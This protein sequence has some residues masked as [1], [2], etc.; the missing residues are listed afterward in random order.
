MLWHLSTETTMNCRVAILL[1]AFA[2]GY[3][4]GMS[5][6]QFE[7]TVRQRLAGDRT[8]TCSAVAMLDNHS[9]ARSVACADAN[10]ACE[11]GS[12]SKTLTARLL[13]Q[14]IVAGKASLDDPLANTCRR[15]P[16]VQRLAGHAG[17]Y[18]LMPG[19]VLAVGAELRFERDASGKVIALTLLQAGQRLRGK[20]G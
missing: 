5:D 7:Q 19:F 3:A 15:V 2:T 6:A 10:T 18:L 4:T 8:G 14:L 12:I 13:A 11:I 17:E 16:S 9:K 1:A 20:R